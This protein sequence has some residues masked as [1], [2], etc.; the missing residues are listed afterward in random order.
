METTSY[1]SPAQLHQRWQMHQESIRRMIR[2]GRLPAVRIGRRGLRV[3]LCDVE[4][5]EL[6]SRVWVKPE[7][8]Q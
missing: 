3:A 7:V 2:Q 5:Y 6:R 1:L 4:A 8:A